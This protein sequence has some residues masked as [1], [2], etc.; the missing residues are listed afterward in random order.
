MP[1]IP[2]C[3]HRTLRW[4]YSRPSA[5]F[6]HCCS[7]VPL[8]SD[9]PADAID[10]YDLSWLSNDIGAFPDDHLEF[11]SIIKP[12][13]AFTSV[14][15]KARLKDTG[16][17]VA[18]HTRA[19][20]NRVE[21]GGDG[22]DWMPYVQREIRALE[23]A[24]D[25]KGVAKLKRAYHM[26]QTS[27]LEFELLPGGSLTERMCLDEFGRSAVYEWEARQWMRPVVETYAQLLA[28]GLYHG[29]QQPANIVFD[30]HGCPKLVDFELVQFFTPQKRLVRSGPNPTG[31]PFYMSREANTPNTVFDPEKATVYS[32][33]QMLRML[34]EL[35]HDPATRRLMQTYVRPLFSGPWRRD[36]S[37]DVMELIDSMTAGM[38]K[39][40]R[41]PPHLT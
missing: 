33:G 16:E 26:G 35:G 14:C 24:S 10:Q 22:S 25:I 18:V 17:I 6:R 20:R 34:L 39:T 41:R 7:R 8:P 28:K 40:T 27:H 21:V 38:V 5:W 13:S 29:D 31:V 2:Q 11:L 32:L 23:A 3:V 36:L 12:G 30:A 19:N 4:L 9:R 15:S 37:A 1:C